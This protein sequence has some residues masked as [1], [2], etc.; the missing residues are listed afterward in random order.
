MFVRQESGNDRTTERP[1]THPCTQQI[2]R[3]NAARLVLVK[4]PR[5]IFVIITV[6]A[7]TTARTAA[8]TCNHDLTTARPISIKLRPEILRK[9]L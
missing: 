3:K 4:G 8:R 2:G 7:G 1:E 5:D 6:W 9:T